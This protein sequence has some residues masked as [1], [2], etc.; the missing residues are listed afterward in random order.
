[1]YAKFKCFFLTII[2]IACCI[3]LIRLAKNGEHYK[4][5]YILAGVAGVCAFVEFI[6]IFTSK[7]ND[8]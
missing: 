7:D 2:N 8:F 4:W 5:L 3:A 6:A 1:M